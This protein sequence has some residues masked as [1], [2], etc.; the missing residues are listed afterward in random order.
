VI[1]DLFSR[2]D[3]QIVADLDE[4]GRV[5]GITGAAEQRRDGVQRAWIM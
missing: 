5:P 1:S 4:Q 2:I 3:Q